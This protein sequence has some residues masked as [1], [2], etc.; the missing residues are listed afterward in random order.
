MKGNGKCCDYTI[1]S[2]K[3]LIRMIKEHV[4]GREEEIN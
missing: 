4:L 2:Q 1:I 3:K